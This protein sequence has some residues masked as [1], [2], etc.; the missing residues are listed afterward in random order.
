M[1]IFK[2]LNESYRS[3]LRFK[4]TLI[5][6]HFGTTVLLSEVFR[7]IFKG[8]A[9]AKKWFVSFLLFFSF[10][11]FYI[12]IKN[13]LINYLGNLLKLIN[14]DS[15]VFSMLLYQRKNIIFLYLF[16]KTLFFV[17]VCC[18]RRISSGFVDSIAPM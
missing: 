16:F 13:Q 2:D 14:N 7:E 12:I 9:K 10:L 4:Q 5:R 1:K 8:I 15:A 11:F 6:Y 3:A 17:V 18:V